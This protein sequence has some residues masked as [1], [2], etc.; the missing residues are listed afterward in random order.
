MVG[1]CALIYVNIARAT[2]SLAMLAFAGFLVLPDVS[3]CIS[4][5]NGWQQS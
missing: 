3:V 2:F 5:C 1:S 4:F